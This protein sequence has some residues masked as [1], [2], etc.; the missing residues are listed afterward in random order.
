MKKEA[1]LEKLKQ[2]ILELEMPRSVIA[3]NTVPL[4]SQLAPLSLAGVFFSSAMSCDFSF[5]ASNVSSK[6]T[7]IQPPFPAPTLPCLE[8]DSAPNPVNI[9]TSPFL[10]LLGLPSSSTPT[11]MR[12]SSGNRAP[13]LKSANNSNS[14]PQ[15]S[16]P[17]TLFGYSFE[18]RESSTASSSTNASSVFRFPNDLPEDPISP[19]TSIRSSIDHPSVAPTFST[20]FIR[21]LSQQAL[22]F[23]SVRYLWIMNFA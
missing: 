23:Y 10:D 14:S 17:S 3:S 20:D 7:N 5:D 15:F 11:P 21:S 6:K 4:S 18:P 12:K 19:L 13:A 22:C 9:P 1:E 2:R 16:F 8:N